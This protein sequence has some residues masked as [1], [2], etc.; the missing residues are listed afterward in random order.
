MAAIALDEDAFRKEVADFLQENWLNGDRKDIQGFRNRA[1]EAGYVYRNVPRQYGGAGQEPNPIKGHIIKEEFAKAGA[2]REVP[3]SGVGLLVPTLLAAGEDWQ[4]DMFIPKTLTGEYTWCQGYSEPGAGSD[5]AAIRT[6]AV[7]E[8][9]HWIINGQKVW[10]S[11][12]AHATHMFILVRSEPDAPKHAGI[13]YLLMEMNQPG[14]QVRPLKQIT[15]ESHFNEIFLDD[16]KT[17][18][19]WI[20]GKRGEGWTV[21]RKT[22]VF[23]RMSISTAEGAEGLFNRLL[24]L[25]KT[26]NLNGKPAIHDPLIRDEIAKVYAMVAAHKAQAADTLYMARRGEESTPASGAFTKL[27]NS[28]IS[29]KIAFVS[30]KII[31]EAALG[32]PTADAPGPVRWTNQFMNSIAAQLGGG[33]S[34]IQRNIIAERALGLPRDDAA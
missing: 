26:T 31:G 13:S 20:V 7:L 25:A 14:V 9:G 19:N 3:G 10:T 5:L 22:L 27:Y 18:A 1:I 34:N 16:A 8:G 4:R 28:T 12:A 15:G 2:P 23:E 24:K 21:S 33:T 6:K 32:G 17:P 11:G 30:Q 29:E